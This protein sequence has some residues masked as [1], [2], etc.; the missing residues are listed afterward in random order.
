[1]KFKYNLDVNLSLGLDGKE[2]FN[3]SYGESGENPDIGD[4]LEENVDMFIGPRFRGAEH[5]LIKA[6][7]KVLKEKGYG[8]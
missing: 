4:A 2:V 3:D 5:V 6:I 8:I 1:M 7:K